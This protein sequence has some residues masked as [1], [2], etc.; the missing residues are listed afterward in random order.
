[1]SKRRWRVF[2][3]LGVLTGVCMTVLAG[4]LPATD[5][6]MFLSDFTRETI[7]AFLF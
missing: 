6:S 2:G 4:C 5:V 1:M 7:A 3:S